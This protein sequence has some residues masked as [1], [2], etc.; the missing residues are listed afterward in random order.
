MRTVPFRRPSMRTL[1]L[2]L[3]ASHAYALSDTRFDGKAGA[4]APTVAPKPSAA[5]ISEA[6]DRVWVELETPGK[7]ERQKA[8]DA[9]V[10]VEELK[11]GSASGFATAKALKR[12]KAAGL[13][14]KSTVSVRQRFGALD[15]P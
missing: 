7:A 5:A 9:G 11:P 15:F 8:V 3:L 1:A 2:V 6:D 4:P 10:S 12:A 14:V 13:K